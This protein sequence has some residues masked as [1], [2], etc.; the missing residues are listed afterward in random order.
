MMI[1]LG[2]VENNKLVIYYLFAESA[3]QTRILGQMAEAAQLV[4]LRIPNELLSIIFQFLPFGDLKNAL[5]VCRL[6]KLNKKI[7]SCFQIPFNFL[8]A[9]EGGWDVCGLWSSLDLKF[10]MHEDEDNVELLYP[11]PTLQELLKIFPPKKYS[12]LNMHKIG[13]LSLSVSSQEDSQ[14]IF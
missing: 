13:C 2:S 12:P 3:T 5:L 14:D 4:N 8:K 11:P 9:V 10:T 1:Q 6:V 7:L